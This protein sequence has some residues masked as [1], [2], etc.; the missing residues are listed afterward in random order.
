LGGIFT[1][2]GSL[3]SFGGIFSIGSA[4]RTRLGPDGIHVIRY[5]FGIVISRKFLSRD[6]VRELTVKESMSSSAGQKKTTYYAIKAVTRDNKKST[7]AFRLKGKREAE[8]LLESI[9]MLSGY[10][11]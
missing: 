7:I 8:V 11:C 10:S 2:L 5:L 1:L 9:R 3:F 6:T 4:L